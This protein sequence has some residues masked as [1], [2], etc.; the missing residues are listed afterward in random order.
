M[1]SSS[2]TPDID[3]ILYRLHACPYCERVVQ[4]LQKYGLDYQSRYVTSEHS[5][6]NVVKCVSGSRTDPVLID[7]DT[8]M[9]MS[10]SAN[11]NQY[12]DR[13]YGDET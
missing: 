9:T 11:I 6:R 8:G 1:S 12:L 4:K 7:Q 13:M 5:T 2:R 10:E 3:L